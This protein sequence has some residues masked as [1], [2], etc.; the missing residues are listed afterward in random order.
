MYE[1]QLAETRDALGAERYDLLTARGAAMSTRRSSS[2][3][4]SRQTN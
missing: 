4:C 2:T 3:R 1:R